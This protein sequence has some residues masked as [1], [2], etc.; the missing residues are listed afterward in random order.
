[1]YVFMCVCVYI[2][3]EVSDHH[4]S[5]VSRAHSSIEFMLTCILFADVVHCT[6]T[7]KG[8]AICSRFPIEASKKWKLKEG[9]GRGVYPSGS[10]AL[11]V[12]VMVRKLS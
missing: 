9:S 2:L 10:G 5:V 6:A 8:I 12:K 4:R 3:R 1:M 7:F 11:V